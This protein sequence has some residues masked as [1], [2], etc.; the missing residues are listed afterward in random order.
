MPCLLRVVAIIHLTDYGKST[1]RK[2]KPSEWWPASAA[3]VATAAVPS[4]TG[5]ARITERY[6]SATRL[7]FG[8]RIDRRATLRPHVTKR[9]AVLAG[10]WIFALVH[11]GTRA[12]KK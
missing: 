8:R 12:Q 1:D 2:R 3:S 10:D 7:L 6:V 4:A 11:R 9:P 5:R